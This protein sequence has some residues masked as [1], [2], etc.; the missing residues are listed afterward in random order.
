VK[1]SSRYPPAQ[2]FLAPAWGCD[3]PLARRVGEEILNVWVNDEVGI[4]YL[5]G[6]VE[7]IAALTSAASDPTE[8]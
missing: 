6:V 2:D 4:D 5:D 3:T 8:K 7:G 1:I